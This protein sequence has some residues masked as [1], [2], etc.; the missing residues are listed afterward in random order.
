[1]SLHYGI[2]NLRANQR[3]YLILIIG[4]IVLV[5][6]GIAYTYWDTTLG[7]RLENVVALVLLVYFVSILPT[8]REY[9]FYKIVLLLTFLPFLSG[10]NSY[11]IYGQ[12]PLK[13]FTVTM[14]NFIWLI[15]FPLKAFRIRESTILHSLLITA[16]VIFVIQVV[17]QLTFP[18][19]YFGVVSEELMNEGG[20]Y[21]QEIAEKRNGLWRFRM[22]MNGYFTTPI[23]FAALIWLK[24]KFDFKMIS[25]FILFLISIYLSLTRL[26][27]FSTIVTIFMSFFLGRRKGTVRSLL[28]AFALIA[29]LFFFYDEFFLSLSKR[30][31]TEM[32]ESNIRVLAASYY[33]QEI[34]KTPLTFLFGYGNAATGAFRDHVNT[35]MSVYHFYASD[36]GFVGKTWHYGIVYVIVCYY[37]LYILFFKYKRQIPLYIRLFVMYTAIMSPM[38]FP[39]YRNIYWLIWAMLLYICELHINGSPLRMKSTSQDL[40]INTKQVKLRSYLRDNKR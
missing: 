11:A 33:I 39:F 34:F 13:T 40:G 21:Q 4:L 18:N 24:Q 27:I 32:S 31:S 16:I 20:G 38:I 2:E 23:I 28:I 10:I 17:Q 8:I 15:Y 36:V 12:P 26:V 19:A 1:M 35:L 14:S 5:T 3:W 29:C 30:T 25:L 9:R 6:N 37:L 7:G 22:H